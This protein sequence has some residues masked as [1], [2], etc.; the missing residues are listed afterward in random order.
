MVTIYHVLTKYFILT[1]G[2]KIGI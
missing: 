2:K 1:L